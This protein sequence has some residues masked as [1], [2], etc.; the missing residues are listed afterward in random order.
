MTDSDMYFLDTCCIIR[1]NYNTYVNTIFHISA[2][3]AHK[4]YRF[5]SY[6]SCKVERENYIFGITA[7]ANSNYRIIG[8]CKGFHL[9]SKNAIKPIIITESSQ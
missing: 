7:S 1:W 9:T 4:A 5:A 8:S 2:V 3:V 6:L